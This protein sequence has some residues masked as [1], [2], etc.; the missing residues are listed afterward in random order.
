MLL[1]STLPH[2]MGAP[3]IV[4]KPNI[5]LITADDLNY[6][7]VGAY[8]C[9]VSKITPNI[10]RLAAEGMKFNHAHVNIAVCQPSRQSVMTG[11]YPHRN[12]AKG[13]QPI[14]E[15]IPTLQ[16]YLKS[17]GYV[18]GILG[19]EV[20]LKPKH[21]YCWDYYIT[22]S[23]LSSG[24]GIGRSPEKYYSFANA[25]ISMA[26]RQGKPFFLMANIHDPHRPF[27][28][29]EQEKKSW[30]ANLPKVT[31][32]IRE[33]E[34]SVPQF[35]PDLPE[36]RKEIAQYFT[37]VHRGD[38]SVGAVMSALE[39]SGLAENTM[40][41]FI[42][43]NGMATPFAKA[44]CYLNSTKTP[45]IVKWPGHVTPGSV[46]SEHVISGIDYMPTVLDAIG[47]KSA[48]G[49]DGTSFLPVLHGKKQTTRKYAFTQFH[50]TYSRSQYPMRAVQGRRYGYLINFWANRT[51]AM[52]MDST[53][54]LAFRSMQQAGKSDPAIAARVALF[55]HR[56]L[57]EF[58]DF[59]KDP[60]ALH[61]LIADPE[62]KDQI[63]EMRSELKAQMA[64][65]HD[66]A[67]QAFVDRDTPS[68][69]D[70]FMKQQRTRARNRKK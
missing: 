19:K 52:R 17:S 22:E 64:K 70:A 26:K 39:E 35:L 2:A 53:S 6:N 66:P 63:S 57:E 47:L 48:A 30:G 61:N 14:N 69:V 37:S 10:D 13:F 31:R 36:I 45:W 62:Y 68:A 21:K 11:C 16:E 54:G 46:D 32:W 27:A 4:R 5:I 25:F 28:G 59:E 9:K 33:D 3:D 8:G 15:E 41:M 51:G 29:S 55:E 50:E 34:I 12:G 49:M 42:S 58:Y 40:V 20:H 24:A 23:Q 56:V 18:N 60:D 7:S 67:L 1:L 38:Q 43:D 65:T 44:N